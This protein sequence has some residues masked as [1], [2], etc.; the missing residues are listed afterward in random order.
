M[1]AEVLQVELPLMELVVVVEQMQ[2]E[3]QELQQ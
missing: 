3:D 2:L 1:L